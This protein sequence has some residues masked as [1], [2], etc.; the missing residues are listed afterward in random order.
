MASLP[1]PLLD[2]GDDADLQR[3]VFAAASVRLAVRGDR[4][5]AAGFKLSENRRNKACVIFLPVILMKS[6]GAFRH[7][8]RDAPTRRER[9]WPAWWFARPYAIMNRKS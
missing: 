6:Q 5:R 2:F 1:T 3:S 9:F 4:A 7:T 8:R